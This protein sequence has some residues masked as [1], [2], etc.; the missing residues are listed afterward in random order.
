MALTPTPLNASARRFGV[1]KN[2][3]YVWIPGTP[4]IA[5]LVGLVPTEVEINA[6][7]LITSHTSGFAGFSATDTY[8]DT[9]D[10]TSDV[11]GK[12]WDG[13][14][15]ADSSISFYLSEDE[16]DALD[17]FTSGDAGFL[18]Q[19]MYGLANE[20]RAFNWDMEVGALNVAPTVSGFQFATIGFAPRRRELITLPAAV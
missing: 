2:T 3:D 5:D 11:T 15:L 4:G 14:T 16:V 9:P 17:F 13:A 20:K 12:V 18:L 10:L 8:A 7:T 6:G 19:C 1:K